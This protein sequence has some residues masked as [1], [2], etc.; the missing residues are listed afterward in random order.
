MP[1]YTLNQNFGMIQRLGVCLFEMCLLNAFL[2]ALP[3]SFK[4]CKNP[5][6]LPKY[7]LVLAQTL[8]SLS[9]KIP[10]DNL[11]SLQH[12]RAPPFKSPTKHSLRQDAAPQH[13]HPLPPPT[14][15]LSAALPQANLLPLRQI[16][17]QAA[18][19]STYHRR[20]QSD[21]SFPF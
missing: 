19:P 18:T 1:R 7:S 15:L 10:Y 13:P 5:S 16:H 12:P 21:D 3:I 8:K 4:R 2:R 17:P 20:N 11:R 6:H 14:V 9:R